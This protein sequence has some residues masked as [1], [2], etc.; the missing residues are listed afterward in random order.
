[1]EYPRPRCHG[2]NGIATPVGVDLASGMW[3]WGDGSLKSI[4]D[5]IK[6]GVPQ[7]KQ[8]PNAMA[9]YGGFLYQTASSPRSRLCL[10]IGHQQKGVAEFERTT[11]PNAV[12][13]FC[14]DRC[15]FRSLAPPDQRHTPYRRKLVPLMETATLRFLL[16]QDLALILSS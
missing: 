13:L 4:T 12:Q 3:L 14:L 15:P 8:H 11:S 9:P 6:N 16:P 2:A 10:G 1:M 7:P 5:T